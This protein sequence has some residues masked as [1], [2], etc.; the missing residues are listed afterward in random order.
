M[1]RNLFPVGSLILFALFLLTMLAT[2]LL[3]KPPPPPAELAGVLRQQFRLIEPF[4]LIDHQQQTFDENNLRG[5]WSLLFFG[6]LSCPDV[7]PMTLHELSAFW[8]LLKDRS[9]SEPQNLQVVFVSLDPGRDSPQA[10]G[11]YVRHFNPRFIA[12]TAPRAQIDTLARQFGVGYVI[13][14]ETAPGQYSLA[15]TS[16]IFLVD[17]LGRS[18]ATFSQPHYASTL[19]E[20][21][22]GINHYFATSGRADNT[23]KSGFIARAGLFPLP[24]SPDK[25]SC[26]EHQVD[27]H[28]NGKKPDRRLVPCGG[29]GDAGRFTF[30]ALQLTHG[31]RIPGYD[32]Q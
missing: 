17:P 11:S 25:I 13:E 10:L 28:T 8:R 31:N 24:E 29:L 30:A 27:H 3:I 1:N 18:V 19:L 32:R 14:A 21:Y 2:Y 16:A 9:G 22:L 26:D 4:S 23:G 15:H 6:Y 7:C 12:A 20:Q 5:K